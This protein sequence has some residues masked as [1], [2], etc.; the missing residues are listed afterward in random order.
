MWR[1]IWYPVPTYVGRELFGETR[2]QISHRLASNAIDGSHCQPWLQLRKEIITL[3]CR[4]SE[5]LNMQMQEW[6]ALLIIHDKV[7]PRSNGSTYAK[8]TIA[9]CIFHIFYACASRMTNSL[10]I[11]F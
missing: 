5:S 6:P 10:R 3:L 8:Y 1:A 2:R 7:R 4:R 11:F 9:F